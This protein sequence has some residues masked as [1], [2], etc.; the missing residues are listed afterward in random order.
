M[1]P[2]TL[3]SA[4]NTEKPNV[5]IINKTYNPELQIDKKNAIPSQFLAKSGY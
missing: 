2:G 4:G 5:Y 1:G 3:G